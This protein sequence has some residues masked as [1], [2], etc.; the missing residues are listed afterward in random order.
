[1]MG[2]QLKEGS[3][4]D[5]SIDGKGFTMFTKGNSAWA[6]NAAKEPELVADMR[7]GTKMTVK[8]VSDRGTNT[9]YTYSLSGVT[10]ALDKVKDCK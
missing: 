3:K 4:V 2:Y 8:A 5:V 10:A 9:E 1:M 6:E 7:A